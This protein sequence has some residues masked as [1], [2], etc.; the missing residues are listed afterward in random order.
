LAVS[1]RIVKALVHP[2][3]MRERA[4]YSHTTEGHPSQDTSC[5]TPSNKILALVHSFLPPPLP[6]PPSSPP[7][8]PPLSSSS[9]DMSSD[10]RF[11]VEFDR[12]SVKNGCE[13]GAGMRAVG[14]FCKRNFSLCRSRFDTCSVS[15]QGLS[16][17]V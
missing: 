4:T 16:L 17:R 6:A 9:P 7:P 8:P 3:P 11:L 2:R 14:V 10:D 12:V 13:L 5:N 1:S 15:V